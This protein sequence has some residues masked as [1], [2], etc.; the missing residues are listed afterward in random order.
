MTRQ[1]AKQTY[2]QAGVGPEDISVI[3]LHDCFT[4]NQ[5]CAMEDLG[6]ARQGEGWKLVEEGRLTYGPQREQGVAAR[7]RWIVNPSGGLISKGH[8][9]GATEIAQCAELT[10]HLRGWT[11]SRAVSSTKYCLAHN[12]GQG[13]ATVVTVYKRADGQVAPKPETTSPATDG[14]GRLGYNPAEEARS[15]TYSDWES[16]RSQATGFSAW[17]VEKLPWVVE[18]KNGAADEGGRA[19]L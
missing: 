14:R 16:V 11:S 4:T 15:I 3:E 6:L 17:A 2:R 8:P 13:G 19:R 9:L 5:M 7:Q 12:M 1:A 10:W 18:R